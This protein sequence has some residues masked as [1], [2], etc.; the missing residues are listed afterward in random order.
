MA[1]ISFNTRVAEH[2]TRLVCLGVSPS[3]RVRCRFPVGDDRFLLTETLVQEAP[4]PEKMAEAQHT[5]MG[6]RTRSHPHALH[7]PSQA[8]R[9]QMQSM[10]IQKRENMPDQT[11]KGSRTPMPDNS[12]DLHPDQPLPLCC[13][14]TVSHRHGCCVYADGGVTLLL[15]RCCYLAALASNTPTKQTKLS[16]PKQTTK[17]YPTCKLPPPS[18]PPQPPPPS[19]SPPQPHPSPPSPRPSTSQPTPSPPPLSP[20]QPACLI[21]DRMPSSTSPPFPTGGR[22]GP[23]SYGGGHDVQHPP[24]QQETKPPNP[25]PSGKR[26]LSSLASL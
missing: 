18:P 17:P 25:P 13:Y 19:P 15:P 26:G 9:K 12:P 2:R 16:K 20:R 23:P 6:T 22:V 1:F 14:R 11:N 8:R 4:A 3:P 21:P 24:Q 10:R 7:T 5:A